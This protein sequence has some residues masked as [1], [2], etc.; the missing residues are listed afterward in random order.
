MK[1]AVF[2]CSR[3][4]ATHVKKAL[5]RQDRAA[6]MDEKGLQIAVV[7][8]G[9]GSRRHFRSDYGAE[10]AVEVASDVIGN[11]F[12]EHNGIVFEDSF[13]TEIKHRIAT[14]WQKR[15]RDHYEQNPLNDA[16]IEEQLKLLGDE[17]LE[18]LI[19]GTDA[20]IPYGTT[21]CAVFHSDAGWG[22]V[23]IGDGCLTTVEHDG[24]FLWPMP[25]SNIN[26]GNK[27]TSLCMKDPMIDFRH[28]WGEDHPA[29][30][31]VYTDG[32][33]KVFPPEGPEIASLLNWVI[34]IEKAGSDGRQAVLEKNLDTLTQR[35]PIGDDLSIAGIVDMEAE[36]IKPKATTAQML[37]EIERTDAKIRE[38]TSTIQYN[39]K[40]RA[41]VNEAD[42]AYK[43]L[44]RII[45]RKKKEIDELNRQREE[46][47]EVLR[48]TGY[49][50]SK[51]NE[52]E[53]PAEESLNETVE[54][55]NHKTE[56]LEEEQA[57]DEDGIVSIQNQDTFSL[58]SAGT[59][60]TIRDKTND[61]QHIQN[62]KA[63]TIV[64]RIKE[65]AR[66]DWRILLLPLDVIL[67]VILIVYLIKGI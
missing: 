51:I 45:F 44:T 6:S 25:K 64:D 52:L 18:K 49:D 67:T 43:E 56:S 41:S 55:I 36:D 10:T 39:E 5:P 9:H 22:S 7:A 31:L 33:E 38:I 26:E 21:L 37:V 23:Q 42:E 46:Q 47:I 28:C 61:T 24:S 29:A 27:T 34:K 63:T 4:G 8:D 32:I 11:M 1:Y 62:M 58:V 65:I 40:K 2:Q 15:I 53:H 35:S 54:Q 50:T 13:F 20:L 19:N 12:K 57:A 48:K 17:R 3:I 30:L 16:E 14:E 59:V 60:E 66:E